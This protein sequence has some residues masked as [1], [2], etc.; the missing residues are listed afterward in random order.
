[1]TLSEKKVFA[2]IGVAPVFDKFHRV[3]SRPRIHAPF[4]EAVYWYGRQPV[5]DLK[6]FYN[7]RPVY[8]FLQRPNPE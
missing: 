6:R 2:K 7:V 3:A 5:E 4:K 8:S 1:M